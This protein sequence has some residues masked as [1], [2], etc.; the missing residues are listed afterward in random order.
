MNSDFRPYELNEDSANGS[1]TFTMPPM[2]DSYPAQ[3]NFDPNNNM[4]MYPFD[5]QDQQSGIVDPSIM[6]GGMSQMAMQHAQPNKLEPS[7]SYVSHYGQI[8]PPNDFTP[9]KDADDEQN[10]KKAH[11][12]AKSRRPKREGTKRKSKS[13]DADVED[14]DSKAPKTTRKARKG[15]KATTKEEEEDSE[16]EAKR[17]KFLERNRVAAS[18]CRMKKKEWTTDLEARARELQNE[19]TRLHSFALQLRDEVLTLKGECLKHTDCN[20]ARIR[21][22]LDRSIAGMNP[23]GAL[24]T[25]PLHGMPMPGNTEFRKQSEASIYTF[26][27]GTSGT[28]TGESR[29]GSIALESDQ[30]PDMLMKDELMKDDEEMKALLEAS[31]A[32]PAGT[33]ASTTTDQ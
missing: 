21:D 14:G 9:S 4:P 23:S 2:V 11:P 24:H 12:K 6:W 29:Q 3:F 1:S 32:S 13:A 5:S 16:G 17:E 10:E 27:S 18:K 25:G 30:D 15:Y 28:A 33:T 26:D 22:Y 8:T 7:T 31:I 19:N 20:C